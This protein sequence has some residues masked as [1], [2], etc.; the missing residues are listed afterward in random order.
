[1]EREL[2]LM[3]LSDYERNQTFLN[4]ALNHAF[5]VQKKDFSKELVTALV[6]GTI[7]HRLMLEYQLEPSVKGKR[8]KLFERMALLMSMYEHLYMNMPDYAIVNEAVRI[9]KKKR[10][11]QAAS[12][13]NAILRNSFE[14]K[15]SLDDL[16]KEE[17]LSIETSHPLWMVKMFIKQY[18]F[19]TCEKILHAN[20]EVPLKSAR[21][22][23]LKISREALLEK[24]HHF[25][26]SSH[27]EDCVFYQGGTIAE[28][29]AFK[30]GW[31]TIQDESSQLVGRFLSPDKG[32]RVLDMCCAPGSK[33]THLSAIMDNTGSIDAY[34][35]YAHKIHLVEDNAKRLGVTNLTTHVGD[36]TDIHCF[37]GE[38]DYILLDGPCSGLGVL[39]RKPEIRYHDSNAMD[40]IILLQKKL[41][42]NA[43]TLC[44]NKG[45]IVYS[46]CTLNKK[47]NEKQVEAFIKAHPDMHIL[48]ERTVLP[49]E[50]HSDGFYMCRLR[51]D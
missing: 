35:L 31:V 19:K 16:K 49:Y 43:Y 36:S 32:S 18:G 24:D 3:I 27:S 48:E 42:E 50:L 46:T 23:T 33:T 1:M 12:F 4:I 40:E 21:V 5:Q 26:A 29:E 9:V 14:H 28:S 34:D 20:N 41:L 39:A 45:I 2:A 38:Y 6:Y 47:E 10:G 30:N 37:E 25:I 15:R 7:Q 51:K 17:R 13:V 11:R 44:K 22:N 8:I